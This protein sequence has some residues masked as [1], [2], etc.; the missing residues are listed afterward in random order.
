M[1]PPPP[2]S[3]SPKPFLDPHISTT[4]ASL[5]TLIIKRDIRFAAFIVYF[6]LHKCESLV[7]ETP[8]P[9]GWP[10]VEV[11]KSQTGLTAG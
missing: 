11:V 4:A 3:E 10:Y 9:L 1:F 2:Y 6:I 7:F 5:K 8:K